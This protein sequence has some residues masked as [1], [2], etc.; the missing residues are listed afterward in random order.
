M[1]C[2]DEMEM[3]WI[4][5]EGQA[6]ESLSIQSIGSIVSMSMSIWLLEHRTV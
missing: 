3:L 5:L 4:A 1:D 6:S 2:M